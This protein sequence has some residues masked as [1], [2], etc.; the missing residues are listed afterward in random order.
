MLNGRTQELLVGM[1]TLLLVG[2]P[3][4]LLVGMLPLLLMG[5]LPLLLVGMLAPLPARDT[6]AQPGPHR[7]HCT[8]LEPTGNTGL[9]SLVPGEQHACVP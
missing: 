3:A 6:G 7:Q 4:L 2:M 1:L 8:G 5:M 9:R